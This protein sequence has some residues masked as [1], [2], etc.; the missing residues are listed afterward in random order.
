MLSPS[1]DT[2]IRLLRA[3]VGL[4]A[5][6]PPLA[7]A[8]IPVT[9]AARVAKSARSAVSAF[10]AKLPMNVGEVTAPFPSRKTI[11]FAL[12]ST[13]G[14]LPRNFH[15]SKFAICAVRVLILSRT[16]IGVNADMSNLETRES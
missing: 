5:P 1:R 8:T 16:A 4:L 13:V 6:V 12:P 15:A 2:A 14:A 3:A 7:T 9:L 11:V 10:P